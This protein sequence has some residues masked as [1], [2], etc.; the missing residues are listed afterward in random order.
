LQTGQTIPKR[1]YV[2]PDV[3]KKEMGAMNQTGQTIPPR[4]IVR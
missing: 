3:V 2:C 1:W 4:W